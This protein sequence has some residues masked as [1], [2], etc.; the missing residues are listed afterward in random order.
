[1]KPVKSFKKVSVLGAGTMG[2]Q[3]TLNC[4]QYGLDTC[5]YSRSEKTIEKFK[6]WAEKYLNGRVEKGKLTRESADEIW[7]RVSTTNSLEECVKDADLVIETVTEV[8]KVKEDLLRQ[9]SDIVAPDV[10][11]ASNS[12]KIVTSTFKDSVKN[13]ARL[14][15]IHFFNPALTMKLTE[16]V[17]GEHTSDETVEALMEFSKLTG[18]TPIHVKKEID[19]FVAN[20][21]FE[22]LVD[23]ANYLLENKIATPQEID[24]AAENGLNHPMG[25]YKTLDFVGLD[26]S[27]DIRK[28]QYEETGKKPYGYDYLEELVKKGRFGR[29]T[30]AGYYDY[31]K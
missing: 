30:D 27:Y 9:V 3:I 18:K 6:L 7:A 8:I 24:L 14:A 13:P 10:I 20:R 29:K 15:N 28:R 25:P 19:G 5:V 11:I 21:L 16:V 23:E 17:Q 22:A 2:S 12:S 1:M 26:V 4:A 31:T